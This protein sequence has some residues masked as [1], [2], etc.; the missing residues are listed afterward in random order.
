L[1]LLGGEQIER[2]VVAA[3]CEIARDE[4]VDR[5]GDLI[6]QLGDIVVRPRGP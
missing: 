2:I 3:T 6:E 1:C 5:A 4:T